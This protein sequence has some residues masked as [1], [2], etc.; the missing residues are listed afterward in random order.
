MK[1]TFKLLSITLLG[2]VISV[3]ALAQENQSQSLRIVR[4]KTDTVRTNV[5]YIIGVAQKG[6]EIFINDMPVKQYKTGSFGTELSLNE[7]DNIVEVRVVTGPS[8]E[9]ESFSVYYKKPEAVTAVVSDSY[10][11]STVPL[12]V[13]KKGAYLNYSTGGD[14]LGGAKINFL[15]EGIKMELLDIK[16]DL[17]KVRL[18]ENR[19][20]YIPKRF[21]EILPVGEET[22]FSL[23]SS[24]SVINTGKADKVTV[25]LEDKHPYIIYSEPDRLIIDV[26]GVNCNTNWITQYLDLEAIE[27]VDL[28]QKESDVLSVIIKLKDKYRWG[29]TVGYTGNR[30][31]IT[32]NHTP[33][34]LRSRSRKPLE[35]LYFG[36]DAGH[37]GNSTGAVSPSGIEE[38]DLNLAMIYMLKEEIENRG[39]KVMLSRS[40]DIDSSIQERTDL[41]REAG[42]DMVISVHCNAG[43]SPLRPMGTSTYYRHIENRPLAEVVLKRLVELDVNN[44]G[45]IGNFNFGLIAPTDYPAILVETMFMSSLPD[46]EQIASP[47]FQKKMM[48]K[49]ATGVEDYIKMVRS[50][51]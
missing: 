45:L 44:F 51:L 28:N 25:V 7:G 2:I 1:Q 21:A 5:H 3:S 35:G 20:A 39:G 50:S 22:P 16:Q 19:Y 38:K 15:D 37:G 49:V 10:S 40:E 30:L 29:Y 4:G 24:W 23:T 13:T 47:E 27:Y 46:E 34:V 8:T 41:F 17:Y 32:V 9:T 31:E 6:S 43:G 11:D 42:V 12:V 14:R 48:T 33:E 36:L 18:S 26:H